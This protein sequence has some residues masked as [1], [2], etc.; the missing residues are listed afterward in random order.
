M[1]PAD[2]SARGA[3][4]PLQARFEDGLRFLAAA[5]ALQSDHRNGAATLS[6]ACDSI[7]CFLPI[8]QAAAERRLEDRNGEVAR[9]KSQCEALLDLDQDP[10]R[11]LSSAIEAARLSRDQA[12]A[13][14]PKLGRP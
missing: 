6:A 3:A 2:L 4:G 12:A 11:L 5:L 10:E 14:I 7:K 8:F 9:L 1:A 13:L